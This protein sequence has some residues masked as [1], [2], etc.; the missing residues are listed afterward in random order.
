MM[1]V[2]VYGTLLSGC[3]NH[4]CLRDQQF[5]GAASIR[6]FALYNL[7]S[8]PGIIPATEEAVQGEVYE[9][10]EETLA[11]LDRLE[12]NGWLYNRRSAEAVVDGK[13]LDAEV[14]VWNGAVNPED[15][16]AVS[17]Q[18]WNDRLIM[19]RYL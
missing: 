9:V 10:D 2:F 18:P 5:L 19:R 11:R 7:G 4:G 3:Y 12:G 1:R 16:I 15:K 6:G 8:Y 17:S 13:S 14:Y